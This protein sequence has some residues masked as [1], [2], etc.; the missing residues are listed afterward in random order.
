TKHQAP[1]TKHQAPSTK[2]QAPSTKRL[3]YYFVTKSEPVMV[4]KSS[5]CHDGASFSL[6]F[7]L[8]ELT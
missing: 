5:F 7:P 6:S 2:H 3:T 4:T 8:V 1:S